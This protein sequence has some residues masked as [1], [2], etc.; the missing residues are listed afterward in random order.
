VDIFNT[1]ASSLLVSIG[2]ARLLL[3]HR[4]DDS[5]LRNAIQMSL[6][7]FVS[8]V[9]ML[10]WLSIAFDFGDCAYPSRQY[11]YFTSGRLMSGAFVP[12]VAVYVWGLDFMVKSKR[13]CLAM[14]VV[15]ALVTT[16]S[17]LYLSWTVFR[18]PYNW[19]HALMG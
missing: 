3:S 8:F 9:G 16:I 2:L 5:D 13:L 12:F 4:S 1:A 10:A 18:S 7:C 17:E 6:V 11:P 15:I 14:I 19:F